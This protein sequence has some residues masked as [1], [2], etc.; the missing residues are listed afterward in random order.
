MLPR[1]LWVDALR[2][3][4]IVLMIVFHFCY[5]LRYFGYVDWSVPDGDYWWP[6]RYIILTLFIF[7]AGL[8]LSL[9]YG[10]QWDTKKFSKR[11]LFVGLSALLVTAMSLLLFP[12]AWIYF[13]ILHF[14]FIAS[15]LS[16]LWLRLPRVAIVFGLCILL[17]YQ[18]EWLDKQWPFVFFEHW[19]PQST[20]DFVPLFPWLGVMLL[21]VGLGG[22]LLQQAPK[23]LFL[24]CFNYSYFQCVRRLGV[25]LAYMGKHSLVIYLVHQPVLFLGFF[26]VSSL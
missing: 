12:T 8:S 7:T 11:S 17:A 19:L 18:F 15:L 13:G 9:A 20:E 14:I 23:F 21:G 1:I 10:Q 16:L 25:G 2:G 3:F 24:G 4:A 22:I 26:M 6:F 5:D